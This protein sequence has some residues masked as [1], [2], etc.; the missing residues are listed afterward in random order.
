M[1][2]LLCTLLIIAAPAFAEEPVIENVTVTRTAPETYRFDVDYQ[3][4]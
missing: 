4:S 2:K 3:T 1:K